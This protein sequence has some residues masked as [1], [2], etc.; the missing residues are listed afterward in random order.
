MLRNS[1]FVACLFGLMGSLAAAEPAPFKSVG[2]LT[3][4]PEITLGAVSA[5]AVD[6]QDNVY[7]LQRGATPLLAWDKDGKFTHGWGDKLFKLPHGLRI[8]AAGDLWTTDNSGHNLRI[9]SS[10]GELLRTIDKAT[11]DD[12]T[13]TAFK[14]PDD[15]VFDSAGN[16]YVADSGNGR[17]LKMTPDAKFLAQWGTKGKGDGQFATAH[18]LAVDEQDRIY[19]GDRGNKRVQQF[20]KDGKHLANWSGFGN[21]FGLIFYGRDLLASEGDAHKIVHLSPEGKVVA[22]WGDK[23]L[24]KLPHLMAKDSRGR[25]YIAEVDGKRVQIFAPVETAPKPAGSP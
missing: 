19:V 17:I 18:S 25:L 8:D 16:V 3:V 21:A 5:V 7:V 4:P 22:E 24:L 1:F 20:D 6:K 2:F 23:E 13:T 9:F 11:K 12:G 15:L 10:R 14:A